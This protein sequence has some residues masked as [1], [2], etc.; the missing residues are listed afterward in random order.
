L[1]ILEFISAETD[2]ETSLSDEIFTGTDGE[3]KDK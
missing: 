1:P 2:K 3:N